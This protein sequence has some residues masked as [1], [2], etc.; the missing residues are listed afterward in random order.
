MSGTTTNYGWTYPTSTDYVKDGATA[1]QTLATGIDTTSAGSNLAGL[2]LIKTQTIGTAV[3]S[4]A[5]TSAFSTTYDAYKIVISGGAAS[6]GLVLQLKIG[7]ATGHYSAG[8][9]S[10]Y[11]SGAQTSLNSS[12]LAQWVYAGVGRT[13]GLGAVIEVINPFLTVNTHITS[14]YNDTS[15][16]GNVSGFLNDTTSYTG[17]TITTST[18]T[19]TGGTIAVYGYR[20]AI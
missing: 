7:G 14:S 19:V 4:I 18:G 10:N 8:V 6:T 1:I 16:A 9:G 5:V 12:N 15:I 11:S 3:S 2:V 20:K 17:F 13:T